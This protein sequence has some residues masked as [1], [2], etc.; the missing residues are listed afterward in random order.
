MLTDPTLTAHDEETSVQVS[1][2]VKLLEGNGTKAKQL[3]IKYSGDKRMVVETDSSI[4]TVF[5]FASGTE[6][7]NGPIPSWK[8]EWAVRGTGSNEELSLYQPPPPSS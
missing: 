7:L 2:Y 8:L 4:F 3:E 1:E 5:A 6:L